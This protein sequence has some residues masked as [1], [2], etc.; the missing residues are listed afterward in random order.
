VSACSIPNFKLE[1]A[2]MVIKSAN[3]IFEIAV[4]LMF[5][6]IRRQFNLRKAETNKFKAVGDLN[7]GTSSFS[8]LTRKD[9]FANGLVIFLWCTFIETI[10]SDLAY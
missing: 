7:D 8:Y 5:N 10:T 1:V 9:R 3:F 2:I 6:R 4:L